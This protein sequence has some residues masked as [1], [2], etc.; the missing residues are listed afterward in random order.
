MAY[1]DE[2]GRMHLSYTQDSISRSLVLLFLFRV[3]VRVGV[4]NNH[5]CELGSSIWEPFRS[6]VLY[7]FGWKVK[8]GRT[9]GQR[10]G[11]EKEK[12]IALFVI[13]LGL[14]ELVV[15]MRGK[16]HYAHPKKRASLEVKRRESNLDILQP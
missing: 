7:Y 9:R 6:H 14:L 8:R 2:R 12:G 5:S 4:V 3:E 15:L 10:Q 13:S 1:L 11:K 16:L